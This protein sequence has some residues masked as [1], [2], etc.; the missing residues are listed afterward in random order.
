MTREHKARIFVACNV[1]IST[2]LVLMLCLAQAHRQTQA[3]FRAKNAQILL[4][5]LA[6]D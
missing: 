5:S 3:S 4:E 6:Q 2:A 1:L